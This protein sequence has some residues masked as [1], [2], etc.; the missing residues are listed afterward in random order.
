MSDL[1]PVSKGADY[2][3]VHPDALDEHKRLGWAECERREPVAQ[4][5]EDDKPAKRGRK[6]VRVQNIDEAEPRE[7]EV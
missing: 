7:I 5:D 4:G 2:I 1:I 6:T 3:E